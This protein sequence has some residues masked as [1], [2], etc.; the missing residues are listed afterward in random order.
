M[1]VALGWLAAI[2][3][4]G[5]DVNP[6]HDPGN[7]NIVYALQLLE[8]DGLS[9]RESAYSRIHPVARQGAATI[10]TAPREVVAQIMR[11][12]AKG[13]AIPA[14]K[15][16]V[17]GATG[18]PVHVSTRSSRQMIT[19]VGW[20]GDDAA[21]KVTPENVRVGTMATMAG[22]MLDQGVLVQ[23]V[24]EDTQILAVHKVSLGG[25]PEAK[26]CTETAELDVVESKPF[27]AE[28]YKHATSAKAADAKA[29]AGV[30][31]WK[32]V[33][34]ADASK[35]AIEIP[36]VGGL[37]VAGEWLVP[38]DGIL[39]ISLGVHTMTGADGKAVVR[40]RLA[41]L[42]ANQANVLAAVDAAPTGRFLLENPPMP[43]PASPIIQPLRVPHLA[44]GRGPTI[45]IPAL[46]GRSIPQGMHA[47][48]TPA[49]APAVPADEVDLDL[50]SETAEAAPSP[51]M[52]ARQIAKMQD[53]AASK[54][55]GEPEDEADEPASGVEVKKIP[56]PRPSFDLGT[57]KVEFTLP[58]LPSLPA[59]LSG[60]S[61]PMSG[62]Q[63]LMPIKPLSIK[64]PFNQKLEIEVIG[65]VVPD[66]EATTTR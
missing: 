3:L 30:E 27:I 55:D 52:K 21:P 5:V 51:Q 33:K 14:P 65:K 10:W 56:P 64:L 4:A 31:P 59:W 12:A 24:L 47:D 1:N 28:A 8:T 54:M 66:P 23:L 53:R 38:D 19:Q 11:H 36:E 41:M 15:L 48:G 62:L 25:C 46:P 13:S 37:E 2:A 18:Q 40:E 39:L 44:V 20:R 35:L 32:T 22:R 29:K 63:F 16:K 34:E 7:R 26:T 42:E 58:K 6:D 17:T 57:N 60:S 49:D 9:W 45:K 61:A 43:E 50:G